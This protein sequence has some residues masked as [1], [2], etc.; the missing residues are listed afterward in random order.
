MSLAG[1]TAEVSGCDIP[2][3]GNGLQ[4]CGG[5][6]AMAEANVPE[7]AA[8]KAR[9]RGGHHMVAV[10]KRQIN[11]GALLTVYGNSDV[12]P[13]DL[14]AVSSD[15]VVDIVQ[16]TVTVDCEAHYV[17]SAGAEIS[18]ES[19]PMTTVTPLRQVHGVGK[20]G[21]PQD[22][23]YYTTVVSGRFLLLPQKSKC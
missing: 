15:V 19:I 23:Q 10:E 16:S 5:A 13:S 18:I 12:Q 14:A 9:G 6:R 3:P 11:S 1:T 21:P 8:F 22:S 2:C 17:P 20:G 7:D 4:M